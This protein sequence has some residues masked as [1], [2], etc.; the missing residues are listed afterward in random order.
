MQIKKF[1]VGYLQTNCYV[2]TSSSSDNAVLIDVG[3]GYEKI[4]R[5]LDEVGKKPAIVLLTHGHFDHILDAH[6]W[7]NIGAKLY[8]HKQDAM[9]LSGEHSL[10]EEMGLKLPVLK[11]DVTINDG[12]EIVVDDLHFSVRH[13]P[14][15]TLGGVCYVFN[16]QYI[17]SGD[18][19]FCGSY[20][21]T[22][23]YGGNISIL[24][25]SIIDKVFSMEGEYVIYPGHGE[26]T[27]LRYEKKHNPILFI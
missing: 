27:D 18:T 25:K 19:I 13:T 20:G 7:Q 9:M 16:G 4:K 6:K 23:F 14:G 21:R 24:K 2:I 5:Y 8:I 22:D 12:E 10:A 1:T 15:H 3:G 17:F 26:S 11:A